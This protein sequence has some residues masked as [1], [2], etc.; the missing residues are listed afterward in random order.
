MKRSLL[1][2][3]LLFPTLSGFGA[4][5]MWAGGGVQ[6]P[7]HGNGAPTVEFGGPSQERSSRLD[8]AR[9]LRVAIARLGADGGVRMLVRMWHVLLGCDHLQ[10]LPSF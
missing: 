9:G 5:Y 6:I 8:A 4:D 1:I 2:I 7:E 10:V 3:V